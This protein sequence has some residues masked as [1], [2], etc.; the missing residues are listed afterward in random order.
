MTSMRIR[1]PVVVFIYRKAE[2]S[3]MVR[4]ET[5]AYIFALQAI[6]FCKAKHR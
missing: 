5:G 2:L 3:A 6:V 1:L 4:Q